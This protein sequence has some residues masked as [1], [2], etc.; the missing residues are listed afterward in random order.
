MDFPTEG[1]APAFIVAQDALSLL[2]ICRELG[3]VNISASTTPLSCTK[4]HSKKPA[5]ACVYIM[6]AELPS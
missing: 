6:K 1:Y 5:Q 3:R 2:E 4:L